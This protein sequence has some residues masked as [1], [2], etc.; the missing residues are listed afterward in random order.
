MSDLLYDRK[1]EITI[2]KRGQSGF[3][4]KDL[5]VIFKVEKSLNSKPNKSEIKVYNLTRDNRSKAEQS[6]NVLLLK[7][8]YGT[9]IETI[10]TGDVAKAKTELEG[11]DYVTTFELGDGE[12][13]FQ[14]AKSDISFSKGTDLKEAIVNILNKANFN[15]G[16]ISGLVSEKLQAPLVL[17]GNVR[18]HLD[19]LAT[20][21][22]FEWSIQ[23]EA[24]QILK[25]GSP[26]K[27]SLVILNSNTGLIGIP[28]NRFGK[29]DDE[30][31][32][33]FDCLLNGKLKPGRRVLIESDIIQGFF[34]IQKVL[35]QG[36]NYGQDFTCKC[37]AA[38]YV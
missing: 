13:L 7:A 31:G 11:V 20:R 10:F 18:K 12:K 3:T 23:D 9:N 6:G 30:K 37:E 16:D 2:G 5:R 26:T 15:L 8:G 38:P 21:Q 32:I 24:V 22:N 17:S 28:K 33:E 19:D 1:I 4:Y 27:E 34:R 35:Y 25:Q 14:T 36:D 29:K